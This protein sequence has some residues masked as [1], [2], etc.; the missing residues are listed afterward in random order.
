[1]FNWLKF[2]LGKKDKPTAKIIYKFSNTEGESEVCRVFLKYLADIGLVNMETMEFGEST[3]LSST[4]EFI[5]TYS[6]K[7]PPPPPPIKKRVEKEPPIVDVEPV[8][9]PQPIRANG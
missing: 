4:N 8:T 6:P 1:M 9:P 2:L 3:Y 5:I 7:P